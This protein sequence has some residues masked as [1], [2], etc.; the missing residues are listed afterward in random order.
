MHLLRRLSYII[1][2]NKYSLY[3]KN[4]NTQE[5]K[6]NYWHSKEEILIISAKL[7]KIPQY[8]NY[9]IRYIFYTCWYVIFVFADAHKL[10]RSWS[11]EHLWIM[12]S[13]ELVRTY[14]PQL[15]PGEINAHTAISYQRDSDNNNNYDVRKTWFWNKVTLS[16]DHKIPHI[17][18]LLWNYK[19]T[20]TSAI[21][22][23]LPSETLVV[24][25]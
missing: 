8:N 21:S 18:A 11:F 19:N 14:F 23:D 6:S 13:C 2:K 15:C 20:N 4:C 17:F 12:C 3:V 1:L 22:D 10:I 25:S 16:G 5:I 9:R 7:F 24:V